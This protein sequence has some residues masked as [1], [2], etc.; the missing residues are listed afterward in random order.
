M[1]VHANAK[2]GPAGRL[3]LTEALQTQSTSQIYRLRLPPRAVE[4]VSLIFPQ[5]DEIRP[6]ALINLA[7]AGN[8][9][10]VPDALDRRVPGWTCGRKVVEVCA[11]PGVSSRLH[12][13]DLSRDH[14][15]P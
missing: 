8:D 7:I 11:V 2:L 3:A 6:V 5:E 1:H 10:D 13:R 15:A 14:Q 9:Q 12:R 4:W